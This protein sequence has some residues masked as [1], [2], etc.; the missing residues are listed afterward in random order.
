MDEMG[1][2]P[3][4]AQSQTSGHYSAVPER[5]VPPLRNK[6]EETTPHWI[7]EIWRMSVAE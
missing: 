3:G 2:L 4:K 1:N 7:V 5:R 6:V